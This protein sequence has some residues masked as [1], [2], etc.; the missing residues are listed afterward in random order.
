MIII[1][2]PIFQIRKLK[3]TEGNRL[4]VEQ[5]VN[6]TIWSKGRGLYCN[7]LYIQLHKKNNTKN[8]LPPTQTSSDFP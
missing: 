7:L 6:L 2:I 1:V 5:V 3:S 4:K 8:V